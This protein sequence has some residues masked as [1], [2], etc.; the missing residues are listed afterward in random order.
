MCF[1]YL[2]TFTPALTRGTVKLTWSHPSEPLRQLFLLA[3]GP[4]VT[5]LVQ[6]AAVPKRAMATMIYFNVFF[7]KIILSFNGQKVK[8]KIYI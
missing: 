4:T 5:V 7:I 3:F 6:P 1:F 2:S 8:L